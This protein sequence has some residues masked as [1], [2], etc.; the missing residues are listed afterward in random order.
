MEGE[1]DAVADERLL[2][3]DAEAFEVCAH[4]DTR[5]LGKVDGMS[6]RTATSILPMAGI[7]KR[8]LQ[9][10]NGLHEGSMAMEKRRRAEV[11]AMSELRRVVMDEEARGKNTRRRAAA[12]K[13]KG[14]G[15]AEVEPVLMREAAK[16]L[17]MTAGKWF[18]VTVYV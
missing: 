7:S 8:W 4:R 13:G 16:G 5:K 9:L 10:A 2:A 12:K 1:D 18:S 3:A 17:T 14:K 15:R 11:K 6:H